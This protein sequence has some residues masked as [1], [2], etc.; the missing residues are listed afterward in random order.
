MTKNISKKFFKKFLVSSILL[1]S[2]ISSQ[3]K[4]VTSGGKVGRIKAVA[5]TNEQQT[6]INELSQANP[7]IKLV[8]ED[9][10]SDFDY[11]KVIEENTKLMKKLQGKHVTKKDANEI[12]EDAVD[13]SLFNDGKGM[14]FAEYMEARVFKALETAGILKLKKSWEV[15][16]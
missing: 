13:N 15:W 2:F 3:G 4:I 5:L 9:T 11:N 7:F 1:A 16:K 6:H 10:K 12:I 8:A 14:K